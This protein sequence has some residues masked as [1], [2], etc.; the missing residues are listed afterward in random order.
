MALEDYRKNMMRCLRCSICKWLPGPNVKSARFAQICPSVL[1]YN[2]HAYS[3]GGRVI[4]AHSLLRGTVEMSDELVDIIYQCQ[5]CGACDTNCHIHMEGFVEPLDVIKEL[6]FTAVG[7]GYVLPQAQFVVDSLRKNDNTVQKPKAE[8]GNWA[9]GLD[10]KDLTKEKAEVVFHAGCCS[11]YEEDLW[12]VLRGAASMLKRGGV[13][14]GILGKEETCCGGRVYNMGYAGEL[15]KYAENNR[16]AWRKAGVKQVVTACADC[17]GAILNNY[18]RVLEGFDVEVIHITQ[19]LDQLI[20]QGKLSPSKQVP[21]RVTYHDPCNLGRLGEKVPAWKGVEKK[22]PGPIIQWDPPKHPR[23]GLGG[24]YQEPRDVLRS[25]PGVE[26]VEM[27]RNKSFSF[28]CGAGGGVID[29][30]PDY[31]LETANERLEEA[32]ATGA[33]ALVTACPWAEKIFKSAAAEF[34]KDLKVFDVV[35]LLAQSTKIE[36]GA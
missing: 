25:I 14:F 11:S 21:M 26:L 5:A 12:P 15:I 6:R 18:P 19:Y 28:C 13:D 23:H 34:G 36:E 10:I 1:K 27:E 8:R 9:Q 16:D 24:V 35:E 7:E 22:L 29:T 30:Y 20:K 2:F 17:Y 3:G 4:T 31:A 32:V 33:E